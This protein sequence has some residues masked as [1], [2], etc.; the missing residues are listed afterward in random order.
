MRTHTSNAPLGADAATD[1]ALRERTRSRDEHE[2]FDS[3]T[4]TVE[5]T[6]RGIRFHVKPSFPVKQKTSVPFFPFKIYQPTNISDFKTGITFLDPVSGVGTVCNIDT[7]QPTNFA[8]NPPTVNPVTDGWRFWAVRAGYI[9]VR[10]I[11]N[12][13]NVRPGGNNLSVSN[14]FGWKALVA[15]NSDGVYPSP[16]TPNNMFDLQTFKTVNPPLIMAGNPSANNFISFVIWIQIT[17]DVAGGPPPTAAIAACTSYAEFTGQ[18]PVQ[19]PNF[20]PV[21]RIAPAN[22]DIIN[23]PY[24]STFYVDQEIFDHV[25]NRF[26]PG[27]GNL[28]PGSCVMNMRG[29]CKADGTTPFPVDLAQQIF[30]PGDCLWITDL[31]QIYQQKSQNPTKWPAGG[32]ASSGAWQWIFG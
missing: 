24:T 20:V 17:P 14:N 6:T 18:F 11:Y 13:F 1:A 19:G 31:S 4:V 27:N 10:P 12:L 32:P 16:E 7:T 30:Y 9:E 5:H 28:S 2:F 22:Q 8:S 15:A 3:T 26:P 21:G 29:Q 23:L 25:S